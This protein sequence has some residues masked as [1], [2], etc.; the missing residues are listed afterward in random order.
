MKKLI[1]KILKEEFQEEK[2]WE[3]KFDMFDGKNDYERYLNMMEI[4]EQLKDKK[5]FTGIKVHGDLDL[6]HADIESL[7]DLTYVTGNLILMFSEIISLGK[8]IEVGKK[9]SLSDTPIRNLGNL[10]KV[11]KSLDLSATRIQS[12][13]K[14][15][16]L[17]YV[18]GYL[19]LS[20]TELGYYTSEEKI[21][22]KVNING[23]IEGVHF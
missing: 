2:L 7:G 23:D 11:G 5:G 13:E 12:L 17:E 1:R 3:V 19:N 21:R 10:K 16:N 15:G 18:G 14:L 6:N 9:L 20:A 4:Y 8:L 22:N